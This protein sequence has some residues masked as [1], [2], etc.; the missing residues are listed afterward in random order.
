ME[1]AWNFSVNIHPVILPG[2][3]GLQQQLLTHFFSPR[4]QCSG[5][6]CIVP[7]EEVLPLGQDAHFKNKNCKRVRSEFVLLWI[8]FSSGKN[9]ESPS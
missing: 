9:G 1:A 8:W 3:A 6:T 7:K 4:I 2:V 5:Y